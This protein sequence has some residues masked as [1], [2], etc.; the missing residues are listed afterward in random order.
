MGLLI[1]ALLLS[2]ACENPAGDNGGNNSN[3]NNNNDNQPVAVTS[4]ALALD[5]PEVI[6]GGTLQLTAAVLPANATDK[7]IAWT[8]AASAV[9]TVNTAG[10]ERR[11]GQ[12]KSVC[13]EQWPGKRPPL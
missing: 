10:P 5:N 9:A 7:T 11:G 3:N 6:K 4:V 12:N 1:C 13:P 2:G 8:S